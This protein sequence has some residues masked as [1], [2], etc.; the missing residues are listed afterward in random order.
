[1]A[2]VV[3]TCVHLLETPFRLLARY[4]SLTAPFLVLPLLHSLSRQG[5]VSELCECCF[6]F[7]QFQ[8]LPASSA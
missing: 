7:G 6:A 8:V 4:A 5:F 2:H 3:E 1:M